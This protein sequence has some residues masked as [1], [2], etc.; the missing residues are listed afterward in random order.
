MSAAS[1]RIS[2]QGSCSRFSCLCQQLNPGCVSEPVV[3]G[4][5]AA[6]PQIELTRS[7]TPSA[8]KRS[9]SPSNS[10]NL[11]TAWPSAPLSASFSRVNRAAIEVEP[12][13]SPGKVGTANATL[14]PPLHTPGGRCC[15]GRVGRRA[16]EKLCFR[17][18]FGL[19]WLSWDRKELIEELC[20]S[21]APVLRCIGDAGTPLW[22]PSNWSNSLLVASSRG[23]FCGASAMEKCS[24]PMSLGPSAMLN[25]CVGEVGSPLSLA[26]GD[27]VDHA[28]I[29]ASAAA[30][31]L[32]SSN[33][34][35]SSATASASE[36]PTPLPNPRSKR[37]PYRQ[38]LSAQKSAVPLPDT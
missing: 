4:A 8:R 35:C 18:L 11:R 5:A 7:N 13:A 37:S 28:A 9:C 33:T 38:N 3:V 1:N 15:C 6:E 30:A 29:A 31:A 23:N 25:A 19:L 26:S 22:R 21:P 20:L 17:G 2:F 24:A 16:A 14:E 36:F 34:A 12:V 27:E 32:P 10:D